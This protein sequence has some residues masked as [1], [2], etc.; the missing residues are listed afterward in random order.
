MTAYDE[1][2]Y[3]SFSHVQS[4]PDAIATLAGLLGLDPAPITGCRVLELGCAGG[5]NLI[6]MALSL[7]GSAFLGLDYS[8][9]QIADGTAAVEALGLTN[10][11]LRQMDIRAVGPELGEFDYI[12]AHGIYSWVPAEVRDRLLAVCRQNLAP[13]GLAYVSYNTYPGWHM[14]GTIRDMM[15]YHVRGVEDPQQRASGARALLNFL[16]EAVPSGDQ[17]RASLLTAYG[18]FLQNE[19]TKL[20]Q[21]ADAFLLHDEL[22]EVNEPVYFHQF[23]EHAE[24]HGLQYVTDV[25]F[26]SSLP[27]FLPPKVRETLMRTARSALEMEQYLDFVRSRTFRQSVLCHA[28]RDVN[29]TLKPESLF[30]CYVAARAVP[31]NTRPDLASKS[32]ERFKGTDGATLAIDHPVSKAA[33]VHLATLWP[34]AIPFEALLPAAL[35][36]LN[37]AGADAA[38][39][40]DEDRQVLAANMLK[41]YVYSDNLVEAHSFAA[42]FRLTPSERPVA[43]PWARRQAEH[44]ARVTN[45]RH[46]RVELDPLNQYLIRHLD[47]TR[48]TEALVDLLLAE[49]VA[50]GKLVVQQDDVT[51]TDPALAREIVASELQSN[52]RWL[53]RAALLVG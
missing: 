4:H 2:P 41:A 48:D 26:R 6:P 47:G 8:A 19:M 14:L 49:P 15:L 29:R 7:P 35:A 33:M 17:A 10:I 38:R 5:G 24:R 9:R 34:Q 51:V 18:K 46:E 53:A 13:G 21:K 16:A 12:V 32:V 52:L 43:S 27:N 39:D 50:G 36:R 25:D 20:G 37:G 42:P 28:G 3:P 30:G 1:V 22:E 23:V 45:L 31:E 40:Q 11:A 44:D